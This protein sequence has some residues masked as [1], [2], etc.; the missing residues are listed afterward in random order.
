MYSHLCILQLATKTAATVSGSDASEDCTS[1]DEAETKKVSHTVNVN[2]DELVH[3][4]L[5]KSGKLV[6]VS[7]QGVAGD[8]SLFT[9][10]NKILYNL[11]NLG[12]ST[13]QCVYKDPG[14]T[15]NSNM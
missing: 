7:A 1:S 6:A 3:V 4:H 5:R 12:A 15:N 2:K 9:P 11:D 13:V 14:D 8:V 10:E